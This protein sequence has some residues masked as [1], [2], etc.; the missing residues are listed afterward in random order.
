MKKIAFITGTT[1]GFGEACAYKFA[2]NHYDLILNGRRWDRLSALKKD[3]EEKYSISCYLLPFDVRDQKVT[4]DAV[5]GLPLQ[6]QQIDV[7]INNAGLALGKDLFD[8][9]VIDDWDTMIDTNVKGLLYVSK[10][11]VPFMIARKK[12]HIINIGSIAGKEVYERGNVYCATKAA[13]DAISQGMR[14]DLL[15]HHIKVT[16]IHPGAAET[17]FSL[18]RLKG[19]EDA[20]KKVYEGYHPLSAED[21]ADVIFYSASL[22]AHVCINDMVITCTQQANTYLFNK[23]GYL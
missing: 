21:V 22:P 3:L 20:A 12:G 18:V 9:A 16:A 14:I 13:V 11:V 8:E 2:Q 15:P 19:K 5:N 1:S 17:E 23:S 7:L 6:W 10:A 4:T